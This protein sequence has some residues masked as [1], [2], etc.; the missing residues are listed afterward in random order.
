M[1]KVE[2]VWNGEKWVVEGDKKRLCEFVD[3][4]CQTCLNPY[5]FGRKGHSCLTPDPDLCPYHSLNLRERYGDDF[6]NTLIMK[7]RSTTSQ[8][9]T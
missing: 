8:T 5:A 7:R 6:V 9:K 3:I 4:E 2:F 1:G